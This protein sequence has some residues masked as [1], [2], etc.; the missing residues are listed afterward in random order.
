MANNGEKNKINFSSPKKYEA[1][2]NYK[3]IKKINLFKKDNGKTP[4]K[5]NIIHKWKNENKYNHFPLK[6]NGKKRR[7]FSSKMKSKPKIKESFEIVNQNI[8]LLENNP[9]KIDKM[10]YLINGCA[11]NFMIHFNDNKKSKRNKEL[12]RKRKFLSEVGICYD[13]VDSNYGLPKKLEKNIFEYKI[14][15]IIYT[16][17]SNCIQSLQI[18]YKNR[19]DDSLITVEND[20]CI[21]KN[22]KKYIIKFPDCLEIKLLGVEKEKEKDIGFTIQCG[23]EI[24]DIGYKQ[25]SESNK[26][27]KFNNQILLGIGMKAC[28]SFGISNLNF[29]LFDSSKFAIQFYD[30]FLQLRAKLSKNAV[31]KKKIFTNFNSFNEKQKLIV[32]ICNLPDLLFYSIMNNLLIL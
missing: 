12:E 28:P 18:I 11:L 27:Q 20:D 31:F 19:N 21:I 3:N 7:N 30:G 16:L 5:L 17:N 13:T 22:K 14:A 15:K 9:N 10:N 25:N 1:N 23:N 29:K 24:Y 6:I 2:K 8:N 4:K 26:K 32:N